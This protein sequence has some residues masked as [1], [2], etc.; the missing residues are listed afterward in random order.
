MDS[1]DVKI[2]VLNLR[3]NALNGLSD[4]SKVGETCQG[5]PEEEIAF[6]IMVVK[7]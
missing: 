7:S 2:D 1:Y 3:G 5:N 4:A 6:K